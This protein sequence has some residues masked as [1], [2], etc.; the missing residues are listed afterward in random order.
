M[1][2]GLSGGILAGN[3]LFGLG[4]G[5]ALGL[6]GM[7]FGLGDNSED[8]ERE[9]TRLMDSTARSDKQNRVLAFNQDTRDAFANRGAVGGKSPVYG[10]EGKA[11]CMLS[12]GEL[13][14][15]LKEGWIKQVPGKPNNKDTKYGR[16]YKDDYVIRNSLV[17]YVLATGD[18]IGA[19]EIQDM[20]IRDK[21]G[22]MTSSRYDMAKCGKMPKYALGTTGEYGLAVLPHFG[23]FFQALASENRARKANTYVP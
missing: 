11:N 14:G 18:V 3:P 20:D 16:L 22:F 12:S 2:T 13:Y 21:D 15:N 17:P 4:I 7:L 5:T 6:G 1:G 19:L 23:E 9:A 8:I 10:R